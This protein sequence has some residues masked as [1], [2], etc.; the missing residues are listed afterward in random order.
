MVQIHV[1]VQRGV[2][3]PEIDKSRVLGEY[4]ARSQNRKLFVLEVT[5]EEFTFLKL[6]YGNENVW[7]R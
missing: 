2:G 7:K 3:L 6:K 5:E 4:Q 1:I